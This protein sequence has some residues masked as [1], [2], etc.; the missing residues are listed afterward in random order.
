[1]VIRADQM[2]DL[3][4]NA[5]QRANAGLADYARRRFPDRFGATPDNV[6]IRIAEEVRRR[7]AADGFEREDHVATYLDLTVMYGAE[8]GKSAWAAPILANEEYTP[9]QRIAALQVRV[10]ESGVKL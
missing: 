10:E 2:G 7:A 6:L 3:A 9:D 8:F 5:R 1:M 4:G